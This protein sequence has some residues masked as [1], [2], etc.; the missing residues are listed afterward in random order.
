MFLAFHSARWDHSVSP[1]GKR[2]RVIGC[3]ASAVQIIPEVAKIASHLVVFQRTRNWLLPR[4]DREI[5]G[6]DT[7][8]LVTAPNVAALT[9]ESVYANADHL[10]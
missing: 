3:A 10:F 1:A 4:L 7:A 2:V 6:E 9:R 5:T 8:L